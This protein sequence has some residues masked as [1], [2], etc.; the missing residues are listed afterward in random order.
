MMNRSIG[1]VKIAEKLK[2]WEEQ[3]QINKELIPR[4][5]KNH[6]MIAD[7]TFQFEK[8]LLSLSLIRD[9]IE[10]LQKNLDQDRSESQLR[11]HTIDKTI[12]TIED[13]LRLINEQEESLKEIKKNIYIQSEQIQEIKEIALKSSS[14]NNSVNNSLI[15][16]GVICALLLSILGI[17]L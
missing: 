7:L 2:F 5:L 8:N 3:D 9:D 4:V 16:T 17:V 10:K 12:H 11:L 15:I 14:K 6:E 13:S 1:E